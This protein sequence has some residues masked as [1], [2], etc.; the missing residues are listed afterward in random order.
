MTMRPLKSPCRVMLVDD[1]KFIA[2]MLAQRLAAESGIE[3]AGFASDAAGAEQIITS[4]QVDIALLDMQLAREDGLG[5]ARRLLELR[6]PLRIIGL[7]VHDQDH[8]PLAL[9][10]MGAAGFLS[11]H[12]SAREIA[13]GVRRVAAGH[14]AVSASVAVFLA[15]HQTVTGPSDWLAALTPKELEVLTCLARGMSIKAVATRLAL[16]SKTVQTHRNNLRKKLGVTTDVE[17][18]LLAIK[19]GLLDLHRTEI[20]RR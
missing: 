3:V 9:L 18:C 12:S 6:P 1:H 20:G 13:D 10:Q 4:Q 16:T 15:T 7:S 19:A 2:E 17:L 14:M 8:Y 11:K 5:V